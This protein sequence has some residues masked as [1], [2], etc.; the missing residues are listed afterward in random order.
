MI[1]DPVV[2]LRNLV[3]SLSDA[4]DLVHL[5]AV[6]HQQ[7]VAYMTLRLAMQAE[8]PPGE[9]T[10]LL[11]AA[12]LHDIGLLSV[13]ERIGFLQGEMEDTD[14]HARM[15]GNLLSR[16]DPF[17]EAAG[18]VRFHH[19]AWDAMDAWDGVPVSARRS[20][21]AVNLADFVERRIRR[22]AGILGQVPGIVAAV[23]D[24][25]GKQ[26]SPDL[27]DA[28]HDLAGVE[29][30]WLDT[31][32]PH[33]DAVIAGMVDWP[34][35]ILGM[36]G[37]EQIGRIL[38]RIVDYRSAY[39]ATHSGGVAASASALARRLFFEERECRLV[40][41]AG[42]LHD[43][44]KVAVPTAILEKPDRLSSREF[45][46][47]RGHAYH[48]FR[49][50]SAIGGFEGITQWAA[51][52][53]ERM[54]GNGYPFHHKGDALPLGSRILAVADVFTAL[55]ENR[56]YRNGIGREGTVAILREFASDGALDGRIVTVL[57]DGYDAI[58]RERREAQEVYAEEFS[59]MDEGEDGGTRPSP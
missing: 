37:L 51:F 8:W 11:Y 15:G 50:L 58:D 46:V 57:E 5:V 42:L 40:R 20:A 7:R 1:R 38:S 59:L 12:A 26:I 29:S 30:F 22:D 36:D 44:G 34:R 21:N 52:H 33:V 54:D 13:E 9:R 49:I 17:R 10:D 14:R 32:S 18:I 27:V 43:L 4:L 35:V 45:D 6:D 2:L 23:D 28:F 39:T 47:I 53:H 24:L 16:F 56:P 41:I 3:L 48:T 55:V 31:V 19:K 25:R